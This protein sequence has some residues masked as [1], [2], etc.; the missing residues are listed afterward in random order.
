MR[1]RTFRAQVGV[2]NAKLLATES[3]THWLASQYRPHDAGDGW[4]EL[5]E[6][7]LGASASSARR[8]RRDHRRCRGPADLG[9]RRRVRPRRGEIGAEPV[10]WASRPTRMNR[11]FLLSRGNPAAGRLYGCPAAH[12]TTAPGSYGP[13][14]LVRAGALYV[15]PRVGLR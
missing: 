11:R 2:D 6:A 7:A 14:R 4:I 5:S 12:A 9:R 13:S 15:R 10:G 8:G 3:R 1:D